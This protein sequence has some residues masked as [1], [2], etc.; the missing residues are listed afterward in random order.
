[1]AALQSIDELLESAVLALYRQWSYLPRRTTIPALEGLRRKL[2]DELAAMPTTPDPAQLRRAAAT[3]AAAALRLPLVG[4]AAGADLEKLAALG[5]DPARPGGLRGA[6]LLKTTPLTTERVQALIAML[7]TDDP[8]AYAVQRWFYVVNETPE[9]WR[10]LRAAVEPLLDR[11][12]D[13]ARQQVQA[14]DALVATAPTGSPL[15][16]STVYEDALKQLE[17]LPGVVA[18]LTDQFFNW[19]EVQR[20][21]RRSVAGFGVAGEAIPKGAMASEDFGP[22]AAISPDAQP[23]PAPETLAVNFHTDVKFPVSVQRRQINWLIVRLRLQKPETTAAAGVVPV[24]FTKIGDEEPPPE[25]LTVRVLAPDFDEETRRWERTITVRYDQ[26]SDPAVFLLKSDEPGKKRITIDFLHKGRQ[27]GSVAFTTEVTEIQTAG[28]SVT[29]TRSNPDLP[30]FARFERTP[31]PPADLHLRVVKKAPEN[32]LA[33]YLDSP[34]AAVPFRNEFMGETP[35]TSKDPFTF[36][37]QEL[38]PLD[39]MVAALTADLTGPERA[40]AERKLTLLA[41]GLFEQLL[42]A[43]FREAYFTQIAPLRDAGV[44]TTFLITSDEPWI[45]WE[46]LKPYHYSV[47]EAKEYTDDFWAARFR[48]SRWLAGRGPQARV[49]VKTA[50][51]VLPDVGLPAVAGERAIFDELS[52]RRKVQLA[53]PSMRRQEVLDLFM[54]GGFQVLHIAT[55]GQFN[56][57]DADQSVIEL[58]D[59]TLRP[60]DLRA[61]LLRGIRQSAPLVFLNACDGGRANFGLTGLGGWAE[62]LFQEANA[63]AF[64][65]ALWEVHDALAVEFSRHFYDRLAEGDTLGEAMRAARTHLRGLDP[66]NPTWLAYTLYGD[67]NAAVQIGTI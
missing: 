42:P 38:D 44:I 57:E 5:E 30:E 40:E 53:G 34:L 39:T 41:E 59:D 51:L 22:A 17:T 54:A 6:P 23:A 60:G 33:F 47:R 18:A 55:H 4:R 15:A 49:E 11:L 43:R 64:V 13:A 56:A 58:A 1:M 37:A 25:Y 35:L 26:D 27:V 62:K 65:G 61:T 67:P 32:T 9:A 2:A 19:K 14:L 7:R 10:T 63:A 50:A 52:T 3:F 21:I 45:P 24:E 66:V 31:P 8:P 48:L 46:L 16:I 20:L 28:A 12:P 29:I 36:L